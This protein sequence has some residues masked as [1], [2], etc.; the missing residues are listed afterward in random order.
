MPPGQFLSLT[1]PRHFCSLKAWGLEFTPGWRSP[2]CSVGLKADAAPH[3][4][5]HFEGHSALPA[6]I[7]TRGAR[8]TLRSTWKRP[9]GRQPLFSLYNLFLLMI[10]KFSSNYG[11]Y[12]KQP[13]WFI[14]HKMQSRN[15]RSWTTDWN[16]FMG[17]DSSLFSAMYFYLSKHDTA[18]PAR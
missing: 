1:Q 3:T 6:P 5:Q 4:A 18:G 9:R 8:S 7:P 13:N 11:T 10:P 15:P 17:E 14:W 16:I 12:L 2:R